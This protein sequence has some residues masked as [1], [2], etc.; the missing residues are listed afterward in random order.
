MYGKEW[1]A[2]ARY[3]DLEVLRCASI[4]ARDN[5]YSL[6]EKAAGDYAE[7]IENALQEI[8]KVITKTVLEQCKLGKALCKKSR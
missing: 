8:D 1:I 4:S 6:R 5:L 7:V 2:I 3:A